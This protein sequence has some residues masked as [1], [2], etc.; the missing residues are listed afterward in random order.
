MT[1]RRPLL[2]QSW[3]GCMHGISISWAP[4]ASI[5]SRIT[6]MILARTFIPSGSIE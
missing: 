1:A 6:L 5:S 4:I 2:I 3:A